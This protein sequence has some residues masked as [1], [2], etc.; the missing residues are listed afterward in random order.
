V[1]ETALDAARLGY[2][3]VVPLAATR[4]VNLRA[5]DDAAA[6]AELERTGV[7]VEPAPR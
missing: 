4:F 7:V 3:V 1:K 5:G 2:E 6:I